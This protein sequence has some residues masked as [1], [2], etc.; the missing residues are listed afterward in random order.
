M[1]LS[2]SRWQ[3]ADLG[4]LVEEELTPY[5]TGEDG[6][7]AAAGPNILLHPATAQALA[8]ALHELATNAAKHGALAATA[9][10]LRLTWKLRSGSLTLLW[11]ETGGP[12][13]ATPAA[14]GYGTRVISASIERQIGGRVAI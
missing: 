9:G 7:I 12:A 6:R 14:Q 13:V 4:K 3:G 2:E 11:A 5:R 8:L 10:K 1:L